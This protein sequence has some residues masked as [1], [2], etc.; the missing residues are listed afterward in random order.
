M[1]YSRLSC[2]SHCWRVRS[3]GVK[4]LVVW[5]NSSDV[6]KEHIASVF[7][8]KSKRSKKP[9]QTEISSET[10]IVF[11]RTTWCYNPEDRTLHNYWCEN[12]KFHNQIL[13]WRI[14]RIW[15]YI[16]HDAKCSFLPSPRRY[17]SGW[18]LAS[19]IT[20][21][22]FFICSDDEASGGRTKKWVECG[23][24]RSWSTYSRWFCINSIHPR[25]IIWF[26]A[27]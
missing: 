10:S 13:W 26:L 8:V 12:I 19:W 24:K 25:F 17:S 2:C 21:L 3:S 1:N 18:A 7:G 9:D 14:L 27:N 4:H 6:S 23:W 22:H 15:H 11:Q 20:S 5:W 16:T